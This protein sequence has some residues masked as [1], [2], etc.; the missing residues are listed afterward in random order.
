MN[1]N[2]FRRNWLKYQRGYEIKSF[3]LLLKTFGDIAR[4]L[5]FDRMQPENYDMYIAMTLSEER[6]KEAYVQLYETIGVSHGLRIG[7]TINKEIKDFMPDT[8]IQNYIKGLADWVLQ[9]AGTRITLVRKNFIKYIKT[10]IEQGLLDNKT[11]IEI[12]NDIYQLIKQDKFYRWQALRIART[13]TTAAA[14]RGAVEAGNNSRLVYEKVW[15]SS[16]DARVR[17]RPPS[18]YDHREMNGVKVDKDKPFNINGEF[19]MYAGAPK[20]A[21]GTLSHGANVINCRCANAIV[22]KRDKDG[23]LIRIL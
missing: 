2:A 7:K 11:I 9:N 12:Q 22:P 19:L 21:M 17:T 10:I 14:N 23:R 4:D 18:D 20:T 15:I 16:Q 5:P 13:E 6:I 8:F 3:K 1:L